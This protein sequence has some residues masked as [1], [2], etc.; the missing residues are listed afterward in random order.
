MKTCN[1]C[2]HK[3]KLRTTTYYQCDKYNKI[4][5]GSPLKPCNECVDDIS[6]R[7][8]DEMIEDIKKSIEEKG[9]KK[10]SKKDIIEVK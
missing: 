1:G 7:P 2:R 4:L 6:S 10:K 5:Y 8:T 9:K 3:K